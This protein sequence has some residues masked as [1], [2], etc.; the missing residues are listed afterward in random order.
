[1]SKNGT[2]DDGT[3]RGLWEISAELTGL[4]LPTGPGG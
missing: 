3:A 2:G 1:M 4:T